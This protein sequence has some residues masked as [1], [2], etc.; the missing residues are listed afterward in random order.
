MTPGGWAHAPPTWSS[1]PSGPCPPCQETCP[2]R[3]KIERGM[4]W[5]ELDPWLRPA[6]LLNPPSTPLPSPHSRPLQAHRCLTPSLQPVAWERQ[7]P[8]LSSPW[9]T[10]A[11]HL[12]KGTEPHRPC[13]P[14]SPPQFQLSTW[15]FSLWHKCHPP[16]CTPPS[17]PP[18][19]IHMGPQEP[20]NLCF[21]EG[22]AQSLC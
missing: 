18:P 8:L 11:P 10:T 13:P 7:P 17:L 16:A 6:A 21:A 3:D 9:A 22:Q 19:H 20:S 12:H 14:P 4:G 5:A 2:Q 1:P 15:N